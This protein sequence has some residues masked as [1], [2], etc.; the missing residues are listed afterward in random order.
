MPYARYSRKRRSRTYRR[1]N[2]FNRYTKG[3]RYFKKRM[4]AKSRFSKKRITSLG[5]AFPRSV[6][7]KL[8]WADVYN[9]NCGANTWAEQFYRPSD[10]YDL[11]YGVGGGTPTPF[12][13]MI[14][15]YKK[16]HV[17]A[18]K[19]NIKFFNTCNQE[20]LCGIINNSENYLY[21]TDGTTVQQQLLEGNSG[22]HCVLAPTG[23][24]GHM[25]TLSGYFRPAS[26]VGPEYKD[27]DYRGTGNANP[28]HWVYSD[29]VI[30]NVDG[31]TTGGT[32]RT[33]V[34]FTLY[35][36]WNDRIMVCTD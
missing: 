33:V 35:T 9:M 34:E 32:V 23:Q 2:A 13:Q 31:T 7:Q 11:D 6:Y 8:R 14:A 18:V 10:L 12:T 20:M 28:T 21:P 26:I 15:L 3:N 24:P 5:T 30:A 16:W 29:V 17:K 4:S 36:Q 27:H 25:K 22:K 1:Y 19:Y